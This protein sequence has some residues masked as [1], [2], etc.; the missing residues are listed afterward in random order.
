MPR[1]REDGPS[2]GPG[3]VRTLIAVHHRRLIGWDVF[4]GD[5]LN[6]GPAG[7]EPP[8]QLSLLAWASQR[9]LHQ[10]VLGAAADRSP[11]GSGINRLGLLGQA[12]SP[13]VGR[14]CGRYRCALLASLLM[15]DPGA[16]AE[17][18]LGVN[19]GL[20]PSRSAGDRLADGVALDE[21]S[22]RAKAIGGDSADGGAGA[23]DAF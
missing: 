20:P 12:A 2:C 1:R 19:Q 4:A 23:S 3:C 5:S 14:C 6:A 7:A 8:P 17:H 10:H 13:T 16:L 15:E 21:A 9:K 11:R 18:L 22:G